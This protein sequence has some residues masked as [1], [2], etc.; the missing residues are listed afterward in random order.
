MLIHSLCRQPDKPT[1]AGKPRPLTPPTTSLLHI[2]KMVGKRCK[3]MLAFLVFQAVIVVTV[4]VVL[5]K[6]PYMRKIA[7]G[8]LRNN[9]LSCSAQS[10]EK[11]YFIR[12]GH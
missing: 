2:Y 10:E 3:C 7:S 6:D 12:Q 9:I 4:L 11:C 1:L 5:S 8:H